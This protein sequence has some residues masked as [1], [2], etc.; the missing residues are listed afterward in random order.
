MFSDILV[1]YD[2][3]DGGQGLLD[4]AIELASTYRSKVRLVAVAHLQPGE[5]IAEAAYPVGL[6][7]VH[8]DEMKKALA[9]AAAAFEQHGCHVETHLLIDNNPAAAIRDLA[10]QMGADLIVLGHR[11]RGPFSR[12]WNGS[13]G[14]A[15]LANPPCSVLV[16]M[17]TLP[18]Q[19][20][21]KAGSVAR[22][23]EEVSQDRH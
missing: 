11:R 18:E 6:I 9:V 19:A 2:G 15:L 14:L 12:L 1:A 20:L 7:A 3:T 5:M 8:E 4:E 16:A 17:S 23:T 13:V 10:L 21:H 22:K